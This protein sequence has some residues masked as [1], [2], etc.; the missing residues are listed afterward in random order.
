MYFNKFKIL[1]IFFTIIVNIDLLYFLPKEKQTKNKK[2][3]FCLGVL[4][5]KIYNRLF[6]VDKRKNIG[7]LEREEKK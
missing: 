3:M 5:G 6:F 1:T 4:W 2:L 7:K